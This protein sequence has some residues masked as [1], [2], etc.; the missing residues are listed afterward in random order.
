M[1]AVVQRV[2]QAQVTVEGE[3]VGA[4]GRGLVVLVGVGVDDGPA[5]AKWLAEKL[6]TL[7]IFEDADGKMNLSCGD[8]GGSVLAISQFT[9]L[10]D[11]RQG[12]RPSF[13]Q[14]ARPES[15][16]PLY[17]SVVDQLRGQ[18]LTVATGRFR[19]EMQVSLVN[20]GPITMLLD[21]KKLF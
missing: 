6:A 5:D 20:D 2:S 4:I 15:A 19:T 21:S 9:L 12:R 11:A 1:R 3:V 16:E 17:Q 18:G 13:T 14:A 7:R 8:V 10:G